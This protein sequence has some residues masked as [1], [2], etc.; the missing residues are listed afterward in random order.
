MKNF[1]QEKITE[2]KAET[3]G[4]KLD[5]L[6]IGTLFGIISLLISAFSLFVL[7]FVVALACSPFTSTTKAHSH[8]S[9]HDYDTAMRQII[10]QAAHKR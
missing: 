9:S 2:F 5:M 6:V 8:S 1:I 4:G 3:I 10:K 7:A